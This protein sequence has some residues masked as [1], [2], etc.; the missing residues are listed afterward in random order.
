[1]TTD[2]KIQTLKQEI[3]QTFPFTTSELLAVIISQ[4][5]GM[6]AVVLT[7]LSTFADRSLAFRVLVVF[8]FI[9][10]LYQWIRVTAFVMNLRRAV[11]GTLLKLTLEARDLTREDFEPEGK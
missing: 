3:D 5:C 9:M 4:I 6:I 1:M 2:K 7:A 11:I 8:A 10:T